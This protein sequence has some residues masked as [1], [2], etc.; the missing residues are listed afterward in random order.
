MSKKIIF[1]CDSSNEIGTGH[2]KRCINLADELYLRDCEIIFLVL[3]LKGNINHQIPAYFKIIEI[4]EI[5]S[6]QEND[7]IN[8]ITQLK[9]HHIDKID[10]AIIDNYSLDL[11]WEEKFKEEALRQNLIKKESIKVIAIDDIANRKH[12]VDILIDQNYFG[13]ISSSRY[14]NLTNKK[15]IKLLGPKYAILS[16]DYI[17]LAQ[18]NLERKSI[19]RLLIFFGGHDNYKLTLMTLQ[20][21]NSLKLENI[22]IDIVIG[23]NLNEEEEIKSIADQLGNCLI[24]KNLK[25]L[26]F[27]MFRAD[28]YIGTGGTTTWER[29]IF[30]LPSLVITDGYNQELI[31]YFLKKDKKIHLIGKSKKMTLQVIENFLKKIFQKK[32][33]LRYPNNI[34]DGYGVLRI[35]SIILG[36]KNHLTF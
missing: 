3:N 31:N 36:Q 4:N 2:V 21:I 20:A 12:S 29:A 22:E 35:S 13:A 8:F 17:S 34:T 10:I 32:I 30:N 25:S 24:H 5:A 7:A 9:S 18:T 1:R 6:N 16:K 27:I 15:C 23:E 19:K 26:S 11:I 28:L 14:D 33:K